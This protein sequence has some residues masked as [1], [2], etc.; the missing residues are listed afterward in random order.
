DARAKIFFHRV[1]P[2]RLH[3]KEQVTEAAA[4]CES[5]SDAR[6][7]RGRQLFAAGF[8]QIREDDG[9]QQKRLK[10]FAQNNDEGLQHNSGAT[11]TDQK[12]DRAPGVCPKLKMIVNFGTRV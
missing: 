10:A 4:E 3:F 11:I 12:S 7:N 6:I 5:R 2:A 9:D 8:A 1:G